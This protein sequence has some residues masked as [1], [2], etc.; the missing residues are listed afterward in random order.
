MQ[1]LL[2]VPRR[3]AFP[4]AR[5]VDRCHAH[6]SKMS[7][8]ELTGLTVESITERVGGGSLGPVPLRAD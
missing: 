6:R 2:L 3:E 4:L 8:R 7:V 1:V 5:V